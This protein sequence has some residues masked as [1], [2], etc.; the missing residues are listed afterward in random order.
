MEVTSRSLEDIFIELTESESESMPESSESD[1]S[2][3]DSDKKGF[4]KTR[5]QKKE[6]ED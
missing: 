6:D 4:W 2:N 5:K 3:A 1:T